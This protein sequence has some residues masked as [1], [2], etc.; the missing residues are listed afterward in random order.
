MRST[1]KKH[2][3]FAMAD[4][5]PKFICDFFIAKAR[6]TKWPDDARYGITATKRTF[7]LAVNRN[8]AKRRLR[9]WLRS[10]ESALNPALDYVFIARSGIADAKLPDGVD[11]M[12][13][14]L[15]KLK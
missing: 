15:K 11:Q 7:K 10:S 12:K 6:P 14:A 1:I 3:D 9:A 5:A 8:R 2:V 4:D 13:R